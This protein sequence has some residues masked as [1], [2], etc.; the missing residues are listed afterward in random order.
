MNPSRRLT[1]RFALA[2]RLSVRF[3]GYSCSPISDDPSIRSECM[4][5]LSSL[6]RFAGGYSPSDINAP[7]ARECV[8]E[9]GFLTDM[10]VSGGSIL[11]VEGRLKASSCY[12]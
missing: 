8:A 5:S 10:I 12:D 11:R 2:A 1:P 4:S 3:S 9:A 7:R 6:R